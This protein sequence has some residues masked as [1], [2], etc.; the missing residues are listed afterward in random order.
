MPRFEIAQFAARSDNFA[1]LLHHPASKATLAIDAPDA[2]AIERV[3]I[4]RGWRLTD[5]FVTHK[6][7]DHIEGIPALKASYNC[8]VTG[9]AASAAETGLY[10]RTVSDGDTLTWAGAEVRTVTTS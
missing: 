1:V 9:P 2:D 8:T 7:L 4:E 3:L 6:H 5:I 10:D